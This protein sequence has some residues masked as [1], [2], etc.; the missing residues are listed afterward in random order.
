MH[1]QDKISTLDFQCKAQKSKSFLSPTLVILQTQVAI[2]NDRASKTTTSL[3]G[4]NLTHKFP[5]STY[6]SWKRSWPVSFGSFLMTSA[7]GKRVF[8]L[9]TGTWPQLSPRVGGSSILKMAAGMGQRLLG[10]EEPVQ[11][12]LWRGV[13]TVKRRH[14]HHTQLT[15]DPPSVAWEGYKTHHQWKTAKQADPEPP[16]LAGRWV[17]SKS[18]HKTDPSLAAPSADTSWKRASSH[19]KSPLLWLPGKDIWGF[20]SLW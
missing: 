1:K 2:L 15:S 8:I 19:K 3:L 9:E 7:R 17:M 10:M 12:T 11:Q 14:G 4:S 13:R 20:L 5:L 6:L 18:N 16:C